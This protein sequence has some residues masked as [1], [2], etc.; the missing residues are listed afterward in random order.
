MSWRPAE[1]R[2][3]GQGNAAR[4]PAVAGAG[5]DASVVEISRGEAIVYGVGVPSSDRLKLS[6]NR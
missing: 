3:G 5:G 6:S 1:V 2:E 4:P